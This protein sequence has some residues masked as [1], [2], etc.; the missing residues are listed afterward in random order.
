MIPAVG[1]LHGLN[2]TFW[3]SDVW[4]YNPAESDVDVTIRRVVRPAS[5]STQHL[6]A[7]G[8]VVLRNVLSTLGGGSAGDGVTLD[9]LVI[10]APYH[11][12]AQLSAYSRTFTDASDGGTYGQAVPAVPSTV[13]YSTHRNVSP[14]TSTHHPMDRS[15]CVSTGDSRADSQPRRGERRRKHE[16]TLLRTRESVSVPPHSV[17]VISIDSVFPDFRRCS[18]RRSALLFADVGRR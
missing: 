8:S 11:R 17:S 13:G 14:A 2:G 5:T 4:L 3:R 10:D 16:V 1:E 18:S 15:R 12:G 9:A 7:H 6:A